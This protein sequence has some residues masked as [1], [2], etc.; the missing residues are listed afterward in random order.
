MNSEKIWSTET[1]IAA[2]PAIWREW[3]NELGRTAMAI[4]EWIEA[5]RPDV[6][7]LCG[8][9]TSA[10][11]GDVLAL[12]LECHAAGMSVRAVPTTDLVARPHDF[13]RPDLR[14]LVVSFGRSGNSSESVGTL[15]LLDKLCPAADR[16]NITCNAKSVLATRRGAGPGQT[17]TILLPEACHDRGFA[18]TSSFTTMLLT[19]LACFSVLSTD[20]TEARLE[21]LAAAADTFLQSPLDL[22]LPERV[23][24]LGSGPLNGMARESALKVLELTAGRIVTSWDS[25]LGFRHGPK[26]VTNERSTVIVF[27]S[28]DVP[29]RSYDIDLVAEIRAQFPETRTITVGC[30][31]EDGVRPDIAFDGLRDDAWNVAAYVLVA[32]RLAVA[33]SKAL[34]LNVDDPFSGR[35]LTRVVTNV[36]LHV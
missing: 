11:I 15:D 2:Q 1:E 13:L 31:S 8:A 30:A 18:M 22:P 36:R 10:F 20:E 23:I 25:A 33:W 26:A 28:N 27:L 6:I 17:R 12:H 14:P 7:W 32:Q 34:D 16:L 24:F 5:R 29:A 3:S 21:R 19:A 9:G 35:N 4:R